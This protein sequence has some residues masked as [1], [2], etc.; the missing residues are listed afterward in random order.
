MRGWFCPGV[1]TKVSTRSSI[2]WQVA[3]KLYARDGA[4]NIQETSVA[5]ALQKKFLAS[6]QLSFY[7]GNGSADIIP[8]NLVEAY[9][10]SFSY[11]DGHASIRLTSK[12]L[13]GPYFGDK[14]INL[15]DVKEGIKRA[16]NSNI[17]E[18]QSWCRDLPELPSMY[19]YNNFAIHS[20]PVDRVSS[21]QYAPYLY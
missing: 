16:M 3:P 9:T 8:G 18:A 4:D 13:T 6:L 19:G 12:S 2:G 14:D 5:E 21:R 20:N 11:A 10:L 7:E 1:P 15:F 17:V